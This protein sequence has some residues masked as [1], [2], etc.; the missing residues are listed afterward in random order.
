MTLLNSFALVASSAL[1][2]P[3]IIHLRRH[4]KVRIVAW[5][6]MQFLSQSML[7][8]RRGL[9]LEEFLLLF[10]R[11]LIILLFAL[12]MARPVIPPG[13]TLRWTSVTGLAAGGFVLLVFCLVGQMTASRR[14][15]G[16]SLAVVLLAIATSLISNRV[17]PP[18]TWGAEQDVAIVIDGSSTMLFEQNSRSHFQSAVEKASALTGRL[19][20]QSTVSIITAGPVCQ[21][22]V[23]SPFR[24]LRSA[25]KSLSGLKPTHG[26]S[27]LSQAIELAKTVVSK[28]VNS[29]KQIVVFTDNQLHNWESIADVAS[30]A[31]DSANAAVATGPVKADPVHYAAHVAKLPVNAVNLSV[32]CITVRSAAATVGRAIPCDVDITNHGAQTVRDLKLTLLLNGQP[33]SVEVIPQLESG[34][35]RTVRFLPVFPSPGSHLLHARLEQPATVPV[36]L[37]EPMADDNQASVLVP[38][39]SHIRILVVN[40]NSFENTTN[41]SATFAQLALDPFSVKDCSAEQQPGAGTPQNSRPVQVQEVDVTELAALETT[42]SYHIVLLC[43]VPRL[44][45]AAA[46]RLMRYV[47][48]GGRLWIIPEQSADRQ[49]YNMWKSD[50]HGEWLLPAE[51][52]ERSQTVLNA[53]LPDEAYSTVTI[54]PESAE[55]PWL[56]EFFERGEHDLFDLQVSSH[57]KLKTRKDSVQHLKLTTGDPLFVEHSVG[58]G[59][60]LLQATSLTHKDSNL[61]TR[62]SFP[63]LMHLWTQSLTT[64]LTQDLNFPPAATLNLPLDDVAVIPPALTLVRPESD[65]VEEPIEIAAADEDGHRFVSIAN[66]VTPGIYELRNTQGNAVFQSFTVTRDRRE[67]DLAVASQEKLNE[68]AA[69]PPFQWFQEVEELTAPGILIDGSHEIWRIPAFAVLWL[70]A[71]EFLLIRWIR[72]RRMVTRSLHQGSLTEANASEVRFRSARCGEKT[73][74]VAVQNAVHRTDVIG[75]AV[76]ARPWTPASP[77]QPEG[78]DL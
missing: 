33:V 15:A 36:D 5:P 72:Q 3:I 67:S 34:T 71:A 39:I 9:R 66:A 54:A 56:K 45:K 58:N 60:V 75:A 50:D 65:A 27:N 19:S 16:V 12:A 47:S 7:I 6:A 29:R 41:Q 35:S 48:N 49:F 2:V 18:E 32:D 59:R 23:G 53:G 13:Q 42:D 73:G 10:L 8:R 25:E 77:R 74:S 62:V 69:E 64:G 43:D 38:V 28:G 63:V 76:T 1:I 30:A 14:T 68:L 78:G 61:M 44:P 57:W 22:V 24:N 40:G 52:A 51:L 55:A 26:G 4:R 20:G 17:L 31:E 11:C 46:E 21:T 37:R 70:L